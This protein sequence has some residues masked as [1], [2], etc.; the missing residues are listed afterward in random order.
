MLH[1]EDSSARFPDNQIAMGAGADDSAIA[2]NANA[3]ANAH[4]LT[5]IR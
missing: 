1:G 2:A 5:A 4:T 3:N